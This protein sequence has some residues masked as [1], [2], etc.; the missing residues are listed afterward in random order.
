MQYHYRPDGQ[1]SFKFAHYIVSFGA[2]DAHI[3]IPTDEDLIRLLGPTNGVD[4]DYT[5]ISE[6]FEDPDQEGLFRGISSPA[7]IAFNASWQGPRDDAG[8]P[9]WDGRF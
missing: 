1:L 9:E 8:L 3:E 7:W 2:E 5:T 4:V 6:A